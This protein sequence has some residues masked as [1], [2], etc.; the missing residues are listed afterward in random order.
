MASIAAK[1]VAE[2]VLVTIGQGKR[3]NVKKIGPKHGYSPKTAGSGLIQK[4][5][6]YQKVLRPLVDQLEA[7]RQAILDRMP[8]VRGKAK[9]RDLVD[10]LDKVTKNLQLLTGRATEHIGVAILTNEDKAKLDAILD[11]KQEGTG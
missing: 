10:G 4:T 7:E 9:Y 11:D 5:K 6:T 2:E 8:K 1:K 3:P